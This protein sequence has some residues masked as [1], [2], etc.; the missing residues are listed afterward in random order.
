[1]HPTDPDPNA[2]IPRQSPGAG[3]AEASASLGRIAHELVSPVAALHSSLEVQGRA[4]ARLETDSNAPE[5]RAAARALT[6]AQT[7]LAQIEEL[8][9]AMRSAG[10]LGQLPRQATPARGLVDAALL[11]VGHR[12]ASVEVER[13]DVPGV[14]L[15]AVPGEIIRVLVNL[16]VNAS[17]A[18]PEGGNVRITTRSG[19]AWG[20]IQVE[21]SGAG[22]A[23]EDEAR[24]FLPGHTSWRTGEEGD[25]H[26]L[27]LAREAVERNGGELRLVKGELSGAAFLVRLPRAETP[28]R[29]SGHRAEPPR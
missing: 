28:P 25:G 19:D 24:I 22:I 7:A 5:Y 1:M 10:R 27:A 21:D 29:P 8:T 15:H 16:L 9:D 12:L 17:R 26:G 23:T 14:L 6:T 3:L 2:D 11:L 18:L 20:E 13:R 4:L